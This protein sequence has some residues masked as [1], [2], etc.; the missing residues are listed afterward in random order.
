MAA[1]S[2]ARRD[3]LP[4]LRG[5]RIWDR[6]SAGLRMALVREAARTSEAKAGREA[7]QDSGVSPLRGDRPRTDTQGAVNWGCATNAASCLPVAFSRK[8]DS[9]EKPDLWASR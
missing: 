7:K 9:E 5:A 1:V 8:K 2:G 6:E 4:R 3:A